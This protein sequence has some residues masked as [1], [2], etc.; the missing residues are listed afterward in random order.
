MKP[1]RPGERGGRYHPFTDQ[2][3]EAIVENIYRILEEVG[4]KD[5]T[6][7]CIETCEAVGA[8]LGDDGR[9]R[10]PRAVV[11]TALKH[12]KRNLT[13]HAQD[14]EFDLDLSGS[15]VHF[16]TAGAAVM[17]ADS[18]K[19]EYRDSTTRDLYDLARIA[20][21]CEHIHMFQR[22]CVL[23]DLEN[24]YE[25]DLN[26]TYCCVAGTRKHVG[27]SWSNCDHL[28]KAL[29]MLHIIAGGE[30][31]WRARALRAGATGRI[32]EGTMG[33]RDRRLGSTNI[34]M[35][36]ARAMKARQKKGS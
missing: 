5:A 26:T 18:M 23:R 4:F 30:A 11:D 15:R 8:V 20:D 31:A 32:L 13:L 7:H 10:M 28:G 25:M 14:P 19:N 1:V 9:L 34:V 16:A 6:P 3:L 29:E 33:Q 35:L 36:Q 22:M 21:N 12:A 24:T 17:I 27:A 2:D